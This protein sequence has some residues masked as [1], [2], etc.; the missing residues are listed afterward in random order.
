LTGDAAE[1]GSWR[2]Y[3]GVHLPLG[4]SDDLITR[5]RGLMR[6]L[7]ASARFSHETAASLLGLPVHASV[8][9][10]H[11]TVPAGVV[12]PRRRAGVI[13]HQRVLDGEPIQ[14]AGVP[15]SRPGQ[16]LL[17]LASAVSPT[18]LVVVG[19]ALLAHGHELDAIRQELAGRGRSRGIVRAREVAMLLRPGVDSPQETRLRLIIVRAGLPEPDVN[20]PVFDAA[21]EW[22]GSPDLGYGKYRIALQYEGDV[23]RSNPRRWRQDIARDEAFTDIGWLVLRAVADD[24]TRPQRFLTRLTRRL[25]ERGWRPPPPG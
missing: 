3:R 5:C 25:Q 15:V 22:I 17:D 14:V 23:H 16:L 13:T 24:I 19:D 4:A 6:V 7:P 12:T 20:V 18:E 10:I 9:Q 1:P 11:V 21:G 8:E 2:P